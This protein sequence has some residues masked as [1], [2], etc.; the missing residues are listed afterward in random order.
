MLPARVQRPLGFEARPPYGPRVS[1]TSRSVRADTGADAAFR[2]LSA[3]CGTSRRSASGCGDARRSTAPP[4]SASAGF[5]TSGRL[6]IAGGAKVTFRSP[7]TAG[8][9]TKRT[10]VSRRGVA[11]QPSAP[12]GSTRGIGA[13]VSSRGIASPAIRKG[14]SAYSG[15]ERFRVAPKRCKKTGFRES[16]PGTQY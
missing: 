10:E 9:Y 5:P 16:N 6:R 8:D 4:G 2:R 11:K 1:I 3:G 7:S 15:D 14:D 12:T 13:V